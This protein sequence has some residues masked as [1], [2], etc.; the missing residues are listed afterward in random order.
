MI[1]AYRAGIPA[2]GKP[3]PDGAKMPRSTGSRNRMS[4][5]P[6]RPGRAPCSTW[7]SW[8]RTA[9]GSRTAEAG[10]GRRL[11][12]TPHPGRSHPPPPLARRH[13]ATTPSAG[14]RATRE[15]RRKTTCLPSTGTGEPVWAVL[16]PQRKKKEERPS[17]QL[18]HV[19]VRRR[20][21]RGSS[22]IPDTPSVPWPSPDLH[23]LRVDAN[24]IATGW[25]CR[26]PSR[27]HPPHHLRPP[28]P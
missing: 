24:V 6:I 9:S 5:S 10:D 26:P 19:H 16:Q 23:G 18:I 20:D 12:T 7:T 25:R 14:W 21:G 1:N 3:V 4:S 22:G 11:I 2:N 15:R 27:C 8:R 13:R 17:A 28:H